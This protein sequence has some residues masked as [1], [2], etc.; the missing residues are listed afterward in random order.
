MK[1]AVVKTRQRIQSFFLSHGPERRGATAGDM[2]FVMESKS[3]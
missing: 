3:E 2:E 1:T